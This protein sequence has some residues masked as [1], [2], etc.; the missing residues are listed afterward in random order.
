MLSGNLVQSSYTCSC[1]L[2]VTDQVK[3]RQKVYSST[4]ATAITNIYLPR[5]EL[6]L[7][8]FIISNFIL[9]SPIMKQGVQSW[10]M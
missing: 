1:I 4:L 2:R 6:T 8:E 3:G 7:T 5:S 9:T 10:S